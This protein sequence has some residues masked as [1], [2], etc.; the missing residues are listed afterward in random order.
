M[1]VEEKLVI[2]NWPWI[3]KKIY[4]E[5]GGS[6]PILRLTIEQSESLEKSLNE[7]KESDEYKCFVVMRC[8]HP[9]S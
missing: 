3:A 2:K 5:L 7:N 9:R 1:K 4:E 8:W 6:S